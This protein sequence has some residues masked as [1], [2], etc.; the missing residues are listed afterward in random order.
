MDSLINTRKLVSEETGAR[1]SQL[2][3]HLWRKPLL[4]QVFLAFDEC[5]ERLAGKLFVTYRKHFLV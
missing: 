3:E 4:L 2:M 1:D 5:L